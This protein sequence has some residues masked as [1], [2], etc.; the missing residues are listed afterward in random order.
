M[1]IIQRAQISLLSLILACSDATAACTGPAGGAGEQFF[2]TTYSMMQFCNGT[3]WVNMGA[4][5]TAASIPSGAV[6]AFNLASCPSGWRAADGTAGT[7]DLR[8]E[9]VRGIDDGRGVDVGRALASSQA[10]SRVQYHWSVGTGWNWSV[11]DF[12]DQTTGLEATTTI[13][14][15]SGGSVNRDATVSNIT[16]DTGAVRP[17][18]VA[19]L[20]CVKN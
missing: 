13:G 8:G 15:L 18:N 5:V 4:N 19:L 9:F 12:P 7:P 11:G 16:V 20:F 14:G 1:Q 2:N 17:R 6:M 10:A 3:N